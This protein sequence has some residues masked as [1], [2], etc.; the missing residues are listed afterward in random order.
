MVVSLIYR[1]DDDVVK[2]SGKI[3]PLISLRVPLSIKIHTEYFNLGIWKPG[4]LNYAHYDICEEMKK[5]DRPWSSLYVPFKE[6]PPN[7]N[8][9]YP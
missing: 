5:K 4:V 1:A 3:V 8:V 6:C 9:G 7:K 2:L